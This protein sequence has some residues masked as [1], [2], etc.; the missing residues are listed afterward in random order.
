MAR[1]GIPETL[2]QPSGR[3]T[4]LDFNWK[5]CVLG[6]LAPWLTLL[7][8][9][10]KTHRIN[11]K[12]ASTDRERVNPK[13]LFAVGVIS[14]VLGLAAGL[15]TPISAPT[16]VPEGFTKASADEFPTSPPSTDIP[17]TSL[18][19]PTPRSSETPS[20]SP[21]EVSASCPPISDKPSVQPKVELEIVKWCVHISFLT[22][23]LEVKV[24][25]AIIN[26][27]QGPIDISLSS[28][29]L[30][31]SAD[32]DKSKWVPAEGLRVGSVVQIEVDGIT[33]WAIPPN[34]DGAFETI[35]MD[36]VE[37]ASYATHWNQTT[38]EQNE[39]YVDPDVKEGD[40][41]WWAPYLQ[42]QCDEITGDCTTE[43]ILGIAIVNDGRVI[44]Y[45]PASAWSDTAHDSPGSF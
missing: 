25:P 5:A 10:V 3:R 8:P 38:L 45:S 12:R 16:A 4:M 42:V 43:D 6:F 39:N 23:L 31:I 1:G 30:V 37:I 35:Q 34:A 41:V 36:G 15:F 44:A 21:S 19:A 18:P 2:G 24:K 13:Y 32:A 14:I 26:L 22:D 20:A 11:A 7:V 28:W 40:I 17:Q 9:L 29:F 33:G 27:S